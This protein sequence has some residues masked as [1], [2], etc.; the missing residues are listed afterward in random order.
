MV[1]L[2]GS[3]ALAYAASSPH[4][5]GRAVCQACFADHICGSSLERYFTLKPTPPP[6]EICDAS[7]PPSNVGLTVSKKTGN[8]R[9]W[10][11]AL[12]GYLLDTP[13][14]VGVEGVDEEEL[15][16]QSPATPDDDGLVSPER[17]PER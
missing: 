3:L 8:L 6:G 12:K 1:V 10:Q 9:A 11:E 4:D 13:K 7:F 14:C 16:K 5:L 15:R 2:D 17:P